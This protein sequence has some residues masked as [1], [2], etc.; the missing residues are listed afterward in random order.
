MSSPIDRPFSSWRSTAIAVE[1]TVQGL[2]LRGVLPD[3]V[4]GRLV[5]INGDVVHVL[6]V[7]EGGEVLYRTHRVQPHSRTTDVMVFGGSILVFGR[8]SLAHQLSS[9]LDTL[10]PVDLAGQSRQLSSCPKRDENTGD[11]H[12][13]ATAPDGSQAQVVVSSGALTRRSRSIIDPPNR[14][15]DLAIAGDHVV[16]ASRGFI[17]IGSRDLES[18]VQWIPTGVDAPAFVHAHSTGETV[19]VYAVT[20]LLERWTIHLA[21]S[22]VHRQVLDPAPQRFA[23]ATHLSERA[24]HLLWTIGDRTVDTY[25]LVAGRRVHRS[26]GQRQPG[27]LGF[28]PDPG[29]ADGGWLVGFVHHESGLTTDLVIL[30]ADDISRPAIAVVHIPRPIPIDLHTTWIPETNQQPHQGDRP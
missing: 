17:G 9:N 20:P 22:N 16:F 6:H 21:S 29:A 15:D 8:G 10:T 30:D 1:T 5:G 23:R 19:F 28:L 4:S 2:T 26:F 11:L 14:V 24:Q 13:L 18:R 25:D 3:A 27:D 12:L 7:H